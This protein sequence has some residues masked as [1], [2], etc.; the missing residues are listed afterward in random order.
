[1]LMLRGDRAQS[2][3]DVLQTGLHLF[4]QRRS[5]L[6]QFYAAVNAIEQPRAQLFLQAFDLLADGR[7][8]GAQLNRRCRK[9]SLPGRCFEDSKQIQGQ[10]TQGV[11]HKLCLS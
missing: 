4:E 8:R 7:L 6:G 11:I 5:G 10:V 3:V 9:A 2:C 1:M